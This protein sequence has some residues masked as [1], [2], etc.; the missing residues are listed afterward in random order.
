[1]SL[2][3][4]SFLDERLVFWRVVIDDER[5]GTE[6]GECLFRHFGDGI[7]VRDLIS[8]NMKWLTGPWACVEDIWVSLQGTTFY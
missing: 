3:G 5:E 2:L 1:V 4:G 6:D 7:R 8:R